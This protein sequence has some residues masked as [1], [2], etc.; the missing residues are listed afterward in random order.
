MTDKGITTSIINVSSSTYILIPLAIV[1]MYNIKPGKIKLNVLNDD[2][3]KLQ[4]PIP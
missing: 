3:V 4:V 2:G 1:E